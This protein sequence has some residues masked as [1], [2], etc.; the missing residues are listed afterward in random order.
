MERKDVPEQYKW[1]TS[2]IFESDEAWEKAFAAPEKKVDFARFRGTLKDAE[3]ILQ[4]FKAE[5][6]FSI[7]AMRVYLYAFLKHDE[8]VR[9][10]KYNSY[11]N[12]ILS[13][14]TKV[15][16]ET[17]FE[18]P[19]LTALPD[20]TLSA[21]QEDPRLKDYDYALSRI[22]A[23]KKYTLSE[24]EEV[25][26][27]QASE[28]LTVA[29]DVFEMLDNAELNLPEIEFEGE[30]VRLSHGLYPV[31]MNGYDRE[32]RKEAYE[33][34]YSAYRNIIST[35]ATTYFGNTKANIFYKTVRG[36]NSCL[37]KA[38]FEED[39][40]AS[41]YERLVKCVGEGTPLMHRYIALRKKLMGY[42]TMYMYDIYPSLVEDAELKLSF[43]EA[44]DLV[45]E[46]LKP[47]GKE[48]LD[49]LRKGRDEGW[50]DVME[51][52]GKRNGAYSIGIYGN[53]P[54][55]LLNYQKTT[56]DV[57]TIAHEMGHS[58]HSHYSNTFQ[59]YP[60]ADYKI[61]V[62]EVAS[63]VN[64]V[65]LLKYLLKTTQDNKLKRYLL[66]YFLD[67]IRTTLFRQTQFAEFEERAHALAEA[68]E[69]LNK[70]NLSEIYLEL[71]KRYYG[72]AVVHDENIAI[73]WA[74]IPHFYRSFYVYKYATGI[75]AA[76]CIA[77]R[78]LNEGEK[79]VEDYKRFLKGGCS[80]DPVS[81]LKIAGADLTQDAPFETAMKE[82]GEALEEFERLSLQ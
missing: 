55:V 6:A 15:S 54:F 52:E 18:T 68:G 3:H 8:D 75:T 37:E 81:L 21:L 69:P 63:T 25:I 7:E 71:N 30:K 41:V 19:E 29:G 50:I 2:D 16:A 61:F 62:A 51:T 35:L 31:I 44:Y 20:E 39:V 57:F 12:K 65:L 26:L 78:I 45:L 36:Y 80:T 32:K 22:R 9:V 53:H 49:L 47:L 42:D 17:A 1:R 59:P 56:H 48:Y 10:T 13:L 4:Y 79:A 40:E 77:N 72:D 28:P 64:E 70:D 46:G 76:I 34:Y 38:L 43:E 24:R 33:L 11:I 27:A 66:N 60:K 74:R 67:M 73:E 14:L 58:L 82:F 23:S 5:E